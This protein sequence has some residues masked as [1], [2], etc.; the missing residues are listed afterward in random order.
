MGTAK[1]PIPSI[2]ETKAF[3]KI[4]NEAIGEILGQ[5]TPGGLEV[6]NSNIYYAHIETIIEHG[7]FLALVGKENYKEVAV[8]IVHELERYESAQNKIQNKLDFKKAKGQAEKDLKIAKKFRESLNHACIQEKEING[9]I[10][11]ISNP[12][13]VELC[14]MVALV[15]R[16]IDALSKFIDNEE[17]NPDIFPLDKYMT[18]E[19]K[20][21]THLKN[22]ID[23]I[24]KKYNIPNY[25]TEAKKMIDALE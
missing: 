15:D 4:L 16:Y 1:K 20:T 8:S 14:K 5:N 25:S 3:F 7:K 19:K 21:K 12:Q 23:K 2:S 17:L 22:L 13:P 9:E 11:T 24:L 10:Y 18:S 6:L